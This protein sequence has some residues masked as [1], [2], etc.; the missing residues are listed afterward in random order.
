MTSSARSPRSIASLYCLKALAALLV[1]VIHGPLPVYRAEVNSLASV[2]VPLFFMITG[3]FLYDE[4]DGRFVERLRASVGK[5]LPIMLITQAVYSV[6]PHGGFPQGRSLDFYIKWLLTGI[7]HNN[8]HLWYLHSLLWVLLLLW[9]LCRL[10]WRRLLPYTLLFI[11]LHYWLAG[12]VYTDSSSPYWQ[13]IAGYLWRY[14]F[15]TA[16][17]FVSLGYLLRLYPLGQ[18]WRWYLLMAIPCYLLSV[19]YL[20]VDYPTLVAIVKPLLFVGFTL[21]LFT[22]SLHYRSLGAGGP[23]A[24]IGQHLSGNVYYWHILVQYALSKTLNYAHYLNWGIIY[25]FVLSCLL[26]FCV[27]RAQRAM[28]IQIL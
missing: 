24:Y 2:A 22:W 27:Q 25:T 28:Q 26:A 13:S 14:T 10:G 4:D 11:P 3:Y 16:L 6:L 23:I 1:V 5:L 21:A 17:P 8:V 18:G 12:L 9:L 7:N 20:R 15:A 19:W